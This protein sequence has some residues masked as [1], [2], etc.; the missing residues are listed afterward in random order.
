MKFVVTESDGQGFDQIAKADS[1]PGDELTANE[2]I[3]RLAVF[4]MRTRLGKEST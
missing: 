4:A 3:R 1:K 2:W